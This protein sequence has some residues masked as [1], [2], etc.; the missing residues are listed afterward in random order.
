[1]RTL[2]MDYQWFGIPQ[3]ENR[4]FK[5]LVILM[6]IVQHNKGKVHPVMDYHELNKHVNAFTA[7]ADVCTA[8]L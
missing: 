1:M 4:P 3:K 7:N 6:A 8:K 2:D 5:G